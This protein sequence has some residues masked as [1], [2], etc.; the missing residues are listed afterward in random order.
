MLI[1]R[2]SVHKT[3]YQANL[4]V[5]WSFDHVV[6]LKS[7]SRLDFRNLRPKLPLDWE[8]EVF[9]PISKK[10]MKFVPSQQG[11]FWWKSK[12][13]SIRVKISPKLVQTSSFLLTVD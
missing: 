4:S 7:I 8:S 9:W 13:R 10:L 3:G 6:D 2:K 11:H 12:V 5:F 1:V